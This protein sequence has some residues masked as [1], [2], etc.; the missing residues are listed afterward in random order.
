VRREVGGWGRRTGE[1]HRC[2]GAIEE[3][4]LLREPTRSHGSECEEKGSARFDRNESF[5]VVVEI[6]ANFVDVGWAR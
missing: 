6:G 4:F 3:R 2:F 5:V 1:I